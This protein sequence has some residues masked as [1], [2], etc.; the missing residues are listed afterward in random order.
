MC[1]SV[2]RHTLAPVDPADASKLGQEKRVEYSAIYK[3]FVAK[4]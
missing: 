3:F 4:P 2:E 1:Q